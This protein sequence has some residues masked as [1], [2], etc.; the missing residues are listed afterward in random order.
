VESRYQTLAEGRLPRVFKNFSPIDY[1]SVSLTL[2]FVVQSRSSPIM[3]SEIMLNPFIR[4]LP[5]GMYFFGFV[6]DN[7]YTCSSGIDVLVVSELE[8]LKLLEVF[9][10]RVGKTL[11][12]W[13]V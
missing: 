6:A 7:R 1:C 8:G 3:N 2:L 11:G 12:D 5:A 9:E 4:Y 13:L 10:V